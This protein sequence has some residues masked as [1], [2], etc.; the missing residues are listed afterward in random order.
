MQVLR[1]ALELSPG[2][3]EVMMASKSSAELSCFDL[4]MERLH[5]HYPLPLLSQATF[6]LRRLEM[7]MA[8]AALSA[9]SARPSQPPP[10][11]K[12]HPTQSPSSTGTDRMGG[13]LNSPSPHPKAIIVGP[14]G[15]CQLDPQVWSIR[16]AISR[17]GNCQTIRQLLVA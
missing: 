5:H 15:Q 3:S 14:G 2:N 9:F 7:R 13:R 12:A 10:D 16:G 4:W 11:P 8:N 6:L 1:Q 17:T